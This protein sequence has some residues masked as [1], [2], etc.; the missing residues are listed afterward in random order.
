MPKF[1]TLLCCFIAIVAKAQPQLELTTG[2]FAPVEVTIPSTPN[3]KLIETSKSWANEFNKRQ[4]GA[5]VSDIT[6]NSMTISAYKKNAFFIRNKGETFQ[7]AIQY[8]IKLKFNVN[9]YTLQFNVTDIYTDQDRLVEYKLPNYYTSDGEFK[10]GYST[11]KPS[12]ERTVNDI[13]TS[14][15]N[16]LLN[17]R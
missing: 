3:E 7:Y 9:S 8:T 14:H 6:A 13:V 15:Y 2:T 10:D 17:F 5:D 1:L 4:K 16:F 12:L 11:I